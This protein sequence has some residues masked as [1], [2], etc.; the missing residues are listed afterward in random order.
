M[1]REAAARTQEKFNNFGFNKIERLDGNIGYIELLR[2]SSFVGEEAGAVAVSTMNFVGNS[3]ALIIDLRKNPGGSGKMGQLL[4]SYFFE[5]GD[6]KWLVSN[7]NRSQGTIKQEWTFSYVPGKRMPDVDLYIL[8]SPNTGSAAEGFAYN[9][10][11]LKRAT[12]VG[13]RSAG[14]AHSGEMAPITNGLVMFVPAGRTINPIT[15]TNWE[16]VG[17]RPDVEV[18]SKDALLKAQSLALEKLQNKFQDEQRKEHVK[19][20]LK[21]LYAELSPVVVNESILKEY[22]GKYEGASTVTF[23]NGE[24]FFQTGA[25]K[26]YR[27]VALDKNLFTVEG[28]N[29]YGIGRQRMQFVRNEK[30]EVTKAITLVNYESGKIATFEDKKIN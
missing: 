13:E 1:N 19:W 2:F 28:A 6:D 22:V 10:Q 20:L 16:G 9:L 27:L 21:S 4:G 11:A 29:Y 24:L 7:Y 23:K 14:G 15:N 8:I 30:G 17:V 25:K 26:E 18:K 3:D 5:P 12:V